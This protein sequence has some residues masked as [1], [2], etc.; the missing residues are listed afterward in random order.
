[1]A[2]VPTF[3]GKMLCP[4]HGSLYIYLFIH[5]FS[6][7][8]PFHLI[9]T[10]MV[11][12]VMVQSLFATPLNVLIRHRVLL[13]AP[14]ARMRPEPYQ[15]HVV[16]CRFR[17]PFCWCRCGAGAAVGQAVVDPP[18]KN[19]APGTKVQT[20]TVKSRIRVKWTWKAKR[21][22]VI[23]VPTFWAY[24]SESIVLSCFQYLLFS[25]IE[26]CCKEMQFHRPQWTLRNCRICMQ[27]RYN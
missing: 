22:R 7:H 8:F 1:M 17:R 9:L 5:L 23:A 27:L 15:R 10:S 19:A 11:T 2:P 12:A 6:F 25:E 13:Q 20:R 24:S 18:R 21:G 4:V 26:F 14:A 16:G 3:C